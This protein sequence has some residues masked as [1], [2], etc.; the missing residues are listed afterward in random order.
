MTRVSFSRNPDF[1]R[2]K[3]NKFVQKSYRLLNYYREH[4]GLPGESPRTKTFTMR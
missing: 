1:I 4:N 2:A 3:V